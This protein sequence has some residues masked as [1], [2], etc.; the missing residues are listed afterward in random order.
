M[1]T[2]SSDSLPGAGLEQPAARVRRAS[3][4]DRALVE[5][6]LAGDEAAFAQVVDAHQG[7]LLRMAMA[8]V[9][10]RAVAEE[11]V[12][13]TWI[14]VLNGLSAFRGQAALKTWIFRILANRA[15]S[16]WEREAR[17]V[18]FSALDTDEPAVDPERFGA[19]GMW[20]APPARWDADTPERIA[21]RRESMECLAKALE[22]LPPGQRA[23]VTLRDV[24]GLDSPDICNVLGISE[25]NQRVLLHR[26][27]S[28]IRKALER[29]I[30]GDGE[31]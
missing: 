22:S 4:E 9:G 21:E 6:L 8:F 12:Q 10:N 1:S 11:V 27:R 2:V 13:E 5:R 15:R 23:V 30:S 29:L 26:G 19:D 14:G 20:T 18:P 31:C 7:A 28:R 16:R 25:T 24:E 17:T 3:A